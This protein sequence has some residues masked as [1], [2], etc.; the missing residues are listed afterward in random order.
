[1]TKAPPPKYAQLE[2]TTACNY[3]CGHCAVSGPHYRATTLPRERAFSL[4]DEIGRLQPPVASL[5]LS[6]HG[7][8]TILPWFSDLLRHTRRKYPHLSLSFQTNGSKLGAL[9]QV[10]V[11]LGIEVVAISV[12]GVGEVFDGIRGA[13][14]YQSLVAG[15][16]AVAERK[17]AAG[18]AQPE[19]RFATVVTK[20]TVFTLVKVVELAVEYGVTEVTLQALTPYRLLDT[21]AW[22][23]KTLTP[24]ERLRARA[25][26]DAARSLAREHGIRFPI[27]HEDVFNEPATEFHHWR[28]PYIPWL[29]PK[30]FRDCVDPWKTLFITAKGT[31]NTCC[32]RKADVKETLATHRLEEMWHA[33]GINRVRERLTSGALDSVC[34]GCSIRPRRESPPDLSAP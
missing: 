12:D 17:I 11:E 18:R 14:T 5:H 2:L 24:G 33:D 1:M 23:L 29:T 21:E 16:R 31:L 3:S 7:E 10:I 22:A 4:I 15:L 20:D 32:L 25:E 34:R 30:T 19:L 6:G 8:S 28:I 9:S 27:L 13:G 26:V